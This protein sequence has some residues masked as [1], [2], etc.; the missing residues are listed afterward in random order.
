MSSFSLPAFYT[1]ARNE[2]TEKFI[3]EWSL[4]EPNLR[5]YFSRF[6]IRCNTSTKL[7]AP[8]T[9]VT[10]YNVK[11]DSLCKFEEPWQ[12]ACRGTTIG[13]LNG[14]NVMFSVGLP[15]FFN[16]MEIPRYMPSHTI[17]THMESLEKEGY[18]LV[19]VNKE[20]GSNIR[21]WYDQ[22]GY[23]HAY[24]LGT[25]TEKEMQESIKDS[26]TFTALAIQLLTHYYPKLLDYLRENP[27]VI[28]VAELKSIWNK[29]VTNY[30]YEPEMNGTITPLV[31]IH[32][33]YP[34]FRMSWKEIAD[35]YP[36]LYNDGN[37]IH[38]MN[39]TASTY[40]S[41]KQH[42][43]AY[44]SA[45]P[46]IFGDNPEGSVLYAV[47]HDKTMCLPVAKAKRP[48]YVEAHHHISLNVGSSTD[49]KS[50]QLLKLLGTYD[51]IT[52]QIGSELRD[53]HIKIMEQALQTMVQFLDSIRDTLIANKD[54]PKV[55]AELISVEMFDSV[56]VGW[57]S[58]YLFKLRKKINQH[59]DSLEFI[60]EC[61]TTIRSAELPITYDI[62]LLQNKYGV[63]WWERSTHTKPEKRPTEP[64][65]ELEP[66]IDYAIKHPEIAIF[67]F[68]ETLYNSQ[69]KSPNTQIITMAQ[70][71]VQ[72]NIPVIIL[73]GRLEEEEDFVRTTLSTFRVSFNQLYCRPLHKTVSI[74]KV[75]MMKR[76]STEYQKIYHFEDNTHTIGQCSQSVYSN[77]SQYAGHTIVD[78]RVSNI[79]YKNDCVFVGLVGPPGS[80]KTTVFN[81]LAQQFENVSWISPDKIATEYRVEHGKKITLEEMHPALL[82]AHKQ[83]VEKGGIIFVDMCHNKCDSIKDIISSGHP[84]VLGTFMILTTVMRKGKQVHTFTEEY[85]RFFT[86]NVTERIQLKKMNGSTLDCENAV[87][88]A[89]KKAEGCL[90]QIL[91]RSI[92]VFATS[93]LT[94][95]E[96]ATIVHKEIMDCLQTSSPSVAYMTNGIYMNQINIQ[97]LGTYVTRF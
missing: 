93:L 28:L 54:I 52:G 56:W 5:A 46:E 57:L 47:N 82:K 41:D 14:E 61:L 27:N 32:P 4:N 21:F 65:C 50:A 37:P 79:T 67:D 39:T 2:F 3:S 48:E 19:M 80:G 40:L 85:K 26:P 8:D 63:C 49:F 11:Y 45:H 84:F 77:H 12:F 15:K 22:F 16:D 74:H 53:E 95:E 70:L 44:Q 92:P 73:T 13:F 36:E 34:D 17:F 87:D 83:A 38:S 96:M 58:P 10:L 29:I 43:F 97:K 76:F 62:Q 60:T 7:V 42:M 64:K 75:S 68:D 69:T 51:D 6:N 91:H 86:K 18:S 9:T 23:L 89:M 59:F 25:T 35:I 33:T 72:L 78:G 55:Y 20:D 81:I 66:S 31:L 1:A 94:P 30:I 88:I 90:H 24:T 71:Y